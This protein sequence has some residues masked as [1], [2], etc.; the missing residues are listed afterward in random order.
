MSRLI[1]DPPLWLSLVL[2]FVV[3][4]ALVAGA[5]L[6]VH[7]ILD[8]LLRMRRAAVL[9]RVVHD[10]R[11][12]VAISLGL[13]AAL[14]SLPTLPLANETLDFLA[15]V[16][17]LTLTATLGWAAT[18]KVAA[19]FDA[20]LDGTQDVADT[21]FTARERRT[22]L[23]IFR[24]LAVSTGI[25]LTVALVLMAIPGVRAIGLSMF[26]SAGVAG[27]VAGLAARPTVANLIAGIQL[28]LTRPVRIGDVVVIEGEWGRVTEIGSTFVIV[29]TW[30]QRSLVVPL[31]Y[32]LERPI[33]NWTRDSSQ[34]LDTV[35]L[36][37]DYTVPVEAIRK[38]AREMVQGSPLWDG[39]V[40]A[41]QVTDI[42]E[43]T[44]QVRVLMSAADS[45][46]MFDLRC[47]VREQLLDFVAREY[48]DVLVRNR[49]EVIAEARGESANGKTGHDDA[50]DEP[51]RLPRPTARERVAVASRQTA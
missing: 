7:R 44:V 45:S 8:R 5:Y 22:Q 3:V 26:A 35:F 33:R 46:R 24:R 37:V 49:V 15:R 38:A 10:G 9:R 20:Y 31:T 14:T 11:V 18:R 29:G 34:L 30:D 19:I 50:E 12:P 27:I 16:I 43:S 39:R 28:A 42:R 51:M 4:P 2:A 41:V 23:V 48:P 36:Y 25:V 40:F 21:D 1:I 32:F 6:I 13:I 47:I 17:G